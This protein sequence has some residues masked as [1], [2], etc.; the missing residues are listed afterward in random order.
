[1]VP[2]AY[3]QED[4][5]GLK[6]GLQDYKCNEES[7]GPEGNPE[8]DFE[9][10]SWDWQYLIQDLQTKGH[11]KFLKKKM[12]CTQEGKELTQFSRPLQFGG[13]DDLCIFHT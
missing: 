12:V 3:P 10:N 6:F 2:S 1:M 11:A 13:S 9:I 4:F 5:W 8:V 7:L